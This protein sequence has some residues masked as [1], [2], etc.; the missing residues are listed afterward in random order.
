MP[1]SRASQEANEEVAVRVTWVGPCHSR[2]VRRPGPV[3]RTVGIEEVRG[4]TPPHAVVGWYG[5]AAQQAALSGERNAG[6]SL[7][8][9][10]FFRAT[11]EQSI[12]QQTPTSRSIADMFTESAV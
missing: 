4:F 12:S 9:E 3:E 10:A 2:G 5:A 1:C 11:G 7:H 8:A 6:L